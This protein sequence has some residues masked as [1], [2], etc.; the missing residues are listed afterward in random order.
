M[1]PHSLIIIDDEES[2]NSRFCRSEEIDFQRLAGHRN[3]SVHFC[4]CKCLFSVDPLEFGEVM[5]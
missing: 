5:A 2:K 1:L 3:V 4:A